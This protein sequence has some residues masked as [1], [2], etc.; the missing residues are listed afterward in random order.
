[1]HVLISGLFTLAVLFDGCR[2]PQ[3]P[4]VVTPIADVRAN[5]GVS[6]RSSIFRASSA[7][8]TPT[9]SRLLRKSAG[10]E[11]GANC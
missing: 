4:V 8:L 2:S 11:T 6:P 5:E 3:P 9:A 7:T 1:M 10:V